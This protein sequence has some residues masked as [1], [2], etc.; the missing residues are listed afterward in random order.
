IED[1]AH[2]VE[3]VAQGRKVG[4]IGDAT[5]FS[6]YVTKNVITGEGGM[7]TTENEQV[8]NWI[9]TAGLHGL[10]KDAWKRYS[11][12]GF[13]H[14]E[15]IF[16]GFKYNMMDLQAAIGIH[17]LAR[18]EE[19]HA[20]REQLWREYDEAFQDLPI[21][22]PAPLAAGDRHARHLYTLLLRLE[23]LRWSRDRVME[24]LHKEGIG[25]G[26]H[27]SALHLHPFYRETY[28]YRSGRFPETEWISERTLS[29][30]FSTKLTRQDSGDVI[31]GVRRVLGAAR[32]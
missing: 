22:R 27:Y 24:A 9:K 1:A 19:N 26:I 13:R 17:Q 7:V 18:V 30:P 8:A 11:D 10:T 3:T 31:R 23:E 20:R 21:D 32:R 4:T 6:F 12:E 28:G 2:A 14:Y 15:V 5:C 29:I 25:T 16:P